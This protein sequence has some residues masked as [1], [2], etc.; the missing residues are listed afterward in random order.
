MLLSS[1][2]TL[3]VPLLSWLNGNQPPTNIHGSVQPLNEPST[4]LQFELRHLHA[5]SPDARVV[6][7]DAPP[8]ALQTLSDPSGSTKASY[9]VRSKR[10]KTYRP[11]SFV[12]HTQ[13]R[14]RSLYFGENEPLDWDDEEILHPDVESRET[15]LELAKMTNNAYLEPS[16]AGWYDLDEKWNV[17]LPFGWEP[18]ADGFRGHVF[19]TPDNST[20]VISIKGTSAGLFGSGGPTQKKDKLNDNLLFSCCCARIDW[21]WSTVCG[22][23]RNGWKCD[24][25]CLEDALISESLFYPIGTNLYNNVSYVFPNANIWVIGHSL[26]GALSSLIGITFGLPVV[27]FEA[28]GERL[29]ATRL[30]LPSPADTLWKQRKRYLS[31]NSKTSNALSVS[32][33]V[34][35]SIVYDTV[36][37]SS[38]SVDVRTH[39]IVTVIDKVLSD[40]WPPSVEIGREVPEAAAEVDCVVC[41]FP[42]HHH[43]E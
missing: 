42:Y 36:S 9:S 32:C 2:A 11:S 24:Q 20:V 43:E 28:P 3:L 31:H 4:N 34:G 10:A 12:A 37:N 35:K 23:Y 38:W 33:H 18:D 29:A 17:S 14:L 25:N 1:V 8:P 15:L 30:H 22:C 16:D 19:A 5:V 26:G 41:F 21:T 39:G 40:P 27:A 6:F 7:A 13:A